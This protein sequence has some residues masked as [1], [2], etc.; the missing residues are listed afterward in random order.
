MTADVKRGRRAASGVGFLHALALLVG[1]AFLG[2]SAVSGAPPVA[3]DVC[4]YG[5]TSGGIVAAVELARLGKSVTLLTPG[6]ALGG[7]TTGGL[8]VTDTIEPDSIGGVAHE[9]YTRV[10]AEYGHP[11][12]Y[13]FEPKVAAKV[14]AEML[15]EA[16]VA[17]MRMQPLAGVIKVGT[18]VTELRT[19]RGL[20]VRAKIFIDATYEGDLMAAA[21]VS[22]SVGRESAA[23]YGE[24]LAGVRPLAPRAQFDV[25]VDPYQ[26]RG[27]VPVG[28]APGVQADPLA[29]AGTG[30]AAVQAYNYRLC[31]TKLPALRRKISRPAGY[32]EE[33]FTILARY[34]AA[35]T[36]AGHILKL[37]D[38]LGFQALPGGKFDVNANGPFSTDWIGGSAA[39]PNARQA[40]RTLITV[41]HRRYVQG[42]LYFLGHSAA[43]PA[44][45]RAEMLEYGFCADEF[46]ATAGWP[47]QLYVREA[48]RM[49]GPYVMQQSDCAGSRTAPDPIALAS[50]PLDSH[51]CQ[52]IV[53]D[54]A[55][56]NEGLLGGVSTIPY[57]ISY[58]AIVPRAEECTNLFVT[59]AVSASHVGFASLR[60]EP[61]LM[62]LSQ[63][64]ADA[65]ALAMAGSL[66]VQEVPYAPLAALLKTRGQ[67]LTWPLLPEGSLVVDNADPEASATG[68]WTLS[69]SA[70][71]FYGIN[72]A[73][74]GNVGRG[75]KSFRFAPVLPAA[76]Q[77]E[78]FL[79][80]TAAANRATNVPVDVIAADGTHTVSID[81]TRR[82]AKWVKLGQWNFAAGTSGAVVIRTA[83][84]NGYVVADAVAF[85]PLP[86]AAP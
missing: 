70:R 69:T 1:W 48:R 6:A 82:G 61:V 35:E 16:G 56:K 63:S 31:L 62:M 78:V 9:F 74:N 8:S 22:F 14:F 71:G 83:G 3:T 32:R 66:A 84:T 58:G 67:I 46:R 75:E 25:P 15:S 86:T 12:S 64:A 52:R 40:Q 10:G 45:I 51:P 54:G 80:W 33:D 47:P 57:G 79:I 30:D 72:Y 50:Y 20:R 37:A 42:L 81:Q 5:A 4:I 26:R 2:G 38:L 21:G 55:V 39:Y 29:T 7:M 41:R 27:K 11:A 68:D 17:P 36:T 49:L 76:G 28:L 13:A 73:H 59:F 23:E 53:D 43:V 34:L 77:Y 85:H 60:M 44:A 18:Q 65:A 24:S 19:V